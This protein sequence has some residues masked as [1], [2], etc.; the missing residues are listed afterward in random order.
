VS[1]RRRAVLLAGLAMV[2]GALA[3][4]DVGRREAEASRRLGA[5]EPVVVA[6]RDLRAGDPL[7]ARRLRT[8]LV[9]RA[10][11]PADR[12]SSPLT[13]TGRTAAVAIRRGTDLSSALVADGV[14][15]G[16]PVRAGQRVAD[17]V[18]EG[19]SELVRPGGHVDVLVT[20]ETAD[21][22]GTTTL[23]LQDAE[24][25][26][27][28]PAPSATDEPGARV[29]VSLRVTLRQAVYLTAAQSFAKSLRI[30]PRAEGDRGRSSGLAVGADLR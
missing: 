28:S 20:R 7:D 3:A 9:P 29:A 14:G 18:A 12:Y 1:H 19:S 8:R 26:A 6:A 4:A 27:A 5:V 16:A 10:F 25:L 11:A 22:S 30:L 21:G 2:L 15:A 17:I 23:A 24:V 13:L